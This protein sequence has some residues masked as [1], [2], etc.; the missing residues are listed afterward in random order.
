MMLMASA[1]DLILLYLGLELMA[2]S[3]FG[4]D[5]FR[6]IFNDFYYNYTLR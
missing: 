2:L 3:I 4:E 5:D 6:H 1:A